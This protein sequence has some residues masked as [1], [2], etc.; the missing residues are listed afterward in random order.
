MTLAAPKTLSARTSRHNALVLAAAQ[1]TVGSAAPAAF[2]V[3]ALAGS[4][5]LSEDKSL[6]TLPVTGFNVGVALAALPAAALMRAIGRRAGFMGGALITAVGGFVSAMALFTHNFWLLALGMVII[7]AGGAFVQQ[8]RFAAIDGAS[9][10]FR[11]K[12]ISWVLAGG[13]FAAV[14][15]PQVVRLTADRFLPTQFVGAFLGTAVLGLLG[16]LVLALLRPPEAERQAHRV[17]ELPARPLLQVMRQPRFVAALICGVGSYSMMS[18]VMTGAPLA[19]VGCGY[20]TDISTLG[21]QWHVM[22]MFAPSFFTGDLIAR[23]GKERMVATGLGLIAASAVVALSGLEIWNFWLSLILLGMGWNFAFIGSTAMVTDCYR[24]AEKNKA[25]GAHDLILFAVV[26]F[27]SFM[28]G[29]ILAASGWEA[30]N[31]VVFP[32]VGIGLLA[33]VGL[34]RTKGRGLLRG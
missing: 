30:M 26:A 8:Y 17:D 24:P 28:S 9:P 5:L 21:I 31:Y 10:S 22:A 27:S 12:A 14:I 33:L 4:W 25:Q 32:V 29:R 13:V 2:A 18:F 11:P 20:S 16:V 6:A 34:S 15:G 3:A 23:Y 19:I 1:A 7:G